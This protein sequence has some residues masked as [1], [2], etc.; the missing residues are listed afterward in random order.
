MK[1]VLGGILIL[2]LLMSLTIS[3]SKKPEQESAD[4]QVS[5]A[6]PE[7][8]EPQEEPQESS[9]EEPQETKDQQ[10][11]TSVTGPYGTI[12]LVLEEGWSAEICETDEDKL[13]Y[14]LYG[15]ILK[16]EQR[17][18]GQIE[19]FYSDSFGVCGTGLKQEKRTIAGVQA[20]IGT[21]DEHLDW[22]FII[23]N[24]D[25]EGIVAQSIQCENWSQDDMDAC[26]RILDTMTFDP[27]I[28]KGGAYQYVPESENADV[29]VI[30]EL[31]QI[32][33]TGATVRF[34]RYDEE[35][36]EEMDYGQAFM[37][38]RQEGGEWVDVE[39]VI[40][41]DY[42]FTEEA[43]P[44]PEMGEAEMETNW[45][46]LYGALPPG[47]YRLRKTVSYGHIGSYKQYPLEAQFIIAG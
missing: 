30:M 41:E 36:T 46:W 47:T 6:E 11:L 21:Y 42:G 3:C 28:A 27:D 29:G 18:K 10:D 39:P 45:E 44:I 7:S 9:Q 19:V 35:K 15:I 5:V 17:A 22:D 1:R 43:Y 4:S 32:S 33:S 31:K 16:P 34:M 2:T 24:G 40:T 12:S 8:E 23:F 13:L 26:L 14:G 38:L 20:W 25:L 37:L